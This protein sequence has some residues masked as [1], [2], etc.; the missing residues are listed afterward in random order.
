M[1]Y[2][3]VVLF[4]IIATIFSIRSS[5][6]KR[7]GHTPYKYYTIEDTSSV[8]NLKDSIRFTITGNKPKPT[9]F[10][11]Q[12]SKPMSL[13]VMKNDGKYYSFINGIFPF[14]KLYRK[15]NIVVIS[16][17]GIPLILPDNGYFWK[18]IS[19]KESDI[20]YACNKKDYYIS[21]IKQVY[22]FMRKKNLML[23]DSN[24]IVGHS[25]GYGVVAKYASLYP[26][27][28]DKVVC[29]SSSIYNIP[30]IRVNQYNKNSILQP[31]NQTDNKESLDSI[32]Q[33]FENI[34]TLAHDK[35]RKYHKYYASNLTLWR[36]LTI[37]YLIKIEKPLLVV[38]G[39]NDIDAVDN[40][41]LPIIFTARRKTNLSI[42]AYPNYDH[43]YFSEEVNSGG[44]T[45]H[46][47][48]HWHEVFID[49]SN[50]LLK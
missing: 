6:Q 36:D 44:N 21:A 26:N 10:F 31:H 48:K 45:V 18:N 37:D 35:S 9:I 25:Q 7:V 46:K 27:D 47:K 13:F 38:Y 12:G 22:D 20:Y 3:K 32:Y 39:M 34:Y 16:K 23:K 49:V 29:M 17:P 4:L 1:I 5:A 2:K 19:K 40:S 41:V 24:Y 14:M 42:F 30:A 8:Y 28:F 43:N 33:D 11:I 50:W 15:F